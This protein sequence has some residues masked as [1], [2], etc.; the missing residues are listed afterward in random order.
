[1]PWRL[2][3]SAAAL[4]FHRA[5]PGLDALVGVGGPDDGQPGHRPERG[6]VLDRLVGRA[7]LAHPDR[8]VRPEVDRVCPRHRGQADRR[9]HVVAEGEEGATNRQDPAVRRHP[10][11]RRTHGVLADAVVELAA[12]GAVFALRLGPLQ[13]HSGVL[14]EVGGAGQE[15]GDDGCRRVQAGVD[16]PPGGE[17]LA[18]LEARQ[19]G[20]PA[21][22]AV[23]RPRRVPGVAVDARDIEPRL[24]LAPELLAAGDAAAVEV[25]HG[26]CM[27]PRQMRFPR[28]QCC[29]G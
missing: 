3:T 8:V 6:Q 27:L 13:G 5:P 23:P 1:M 28:L 4:G 7:V 24:P 15:S 17:L 16:G 2:R 21:F 20:F 12:S 19:L 14:G 22:E 29:H 11:H 25:E 18:G 26:V 9:A 10:G